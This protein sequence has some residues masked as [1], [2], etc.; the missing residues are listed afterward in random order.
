MNI[1]DEIDDLIVRFRERGIVLQDTYT[2]SG[3]GE[4]VAIKLE[5]TGYLD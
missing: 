2:L 5:I 1:Q 3:K 4:I